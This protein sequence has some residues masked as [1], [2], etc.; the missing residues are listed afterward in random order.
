M[1]KPSALVF[2]H[3]FP[4]NSKM[5][6]KQ[7]EFFSKDYPCFALDLPGYGREPLPAGAVTFEAYVDCF[8]ARL[9]EWGLVRSTWIGCSMGGYLILRALERLPELCER[10][11]LCDT[12][13]EPDGNE[14]KIKRWASHGA[15]RQD[16]DTFLA[17][18]WKSLVGEKAAIDP[19]LFE[20][21][22]A[23]VSENAPEG[24]LAGLVAL[25]TRT[26]TRKVL[27]RVRVPSLVIVGAEDKVTP[28][29]DAEALHRGIAGS[30]LEVLQGVGH[31]PN[32]EAPEVF[33]RALKGFFESA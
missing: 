13:A 18:Q 4:L 15:F 28:P 29:E 14:A 24:V 20:R 16:R 11:V 5:W 2:V 7:V 25:A 23:L 31:L 6:E 17:N 26:D 3:A 19:A 32:L 9:K 1:S 8:E 30:R 10:V 12:K 27:A 22:R 33:N 21:F